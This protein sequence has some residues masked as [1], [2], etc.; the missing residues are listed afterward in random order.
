MPIKHE[1]KLNTL[2]AVR[3]YAECFILRIALAVTIKQGNAL[4][5]L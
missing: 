1:A 4:N 3:P 5:V 2:L